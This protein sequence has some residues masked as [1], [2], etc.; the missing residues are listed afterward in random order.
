MEQLGYV[1]VTV[2]LLLFV[3]GSKL[4]RFKNVLL[5]KKNLFCTEFIRKERFL[6][7]L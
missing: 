2:V 3:H 1:Q 6:T 4:C 5:K 7:H